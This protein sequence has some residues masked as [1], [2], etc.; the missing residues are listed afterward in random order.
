[1]STYL[2]NKK[3]LIVAV[4][5]IILLLLLG[6]Q[7]VIA[8]E[9]NNNVEP[10]TEVNVAI[11]QE[12]EKYLPVDDSSVLLQQKLNI[13]SNNI[14][15]KEQEDIYVSVPKLMDKLPDTVVVLYNGDKL[16]DNLYSYIIEE[17]Q[18]FI[19]NLN[20]QNEMDNTAEYTIIYGYMDTTVEEVSVYSHVDVNMKLVDNP[21]IFSRQ[22][23]YEATINLMGNK[24][25]VSGS[26]STGLTKGYMYSGNK[27]NIRFAERYYVEV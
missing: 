17:G 12:I 8:D 21:N 5:F 3:T 11:S 26:M 9:N 4:I 24:V 13:E 22:N 20:S 23:D 1:M 27:E 7:L 2:K 18:L 16:Q 6:S 19:Q 10:E 14:A 25:S 15:G